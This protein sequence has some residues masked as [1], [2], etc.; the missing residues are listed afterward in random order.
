MRYS[1]LLPV[2]AKSNPVHRTSVM[3]TEPKTER[4]KRRRKE[5]HL[6]DLLLIDLANIDTM[7]GMISEERNSLTERKKAIEVLLKSYDG[8]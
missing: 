1:Q 7:L 5:Q 8:K 3:T 6:A 2:A 4:G